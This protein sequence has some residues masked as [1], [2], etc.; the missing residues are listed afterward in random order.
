MAHSTHAFGADSL[1][2]RDSI[3]RLAFGLAPGT[4]AAGGAGL[5]ATGE[6]CSAAALGKAMGAE[7]GAAAL[8]ATAFGGTVAGAMA[9]GAAAWAALAAG[10][11]TVAGGTS[12]TLGF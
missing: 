5:S 1:S 2:Q 8:G 11:A 9:V 12:A 4:T 6:R 7:L 10:T 3:F